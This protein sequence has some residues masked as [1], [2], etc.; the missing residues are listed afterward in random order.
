M[1][2]LFLLVD[3]LTDRDS[4]VA[5]LHSFFTSGT[6]STAL[7]IFLGCC[8]AIRL[9]FLRGRH[10]VVSRTQKSA[11]ISEATQS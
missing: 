11:K 5:C 6:V 1:K 4:I 2:T 8:Q 3:L 9:S 10:P 7:L